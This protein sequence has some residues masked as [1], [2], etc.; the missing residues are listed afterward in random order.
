MPTF[1]RDCPNPPLQATAYGESAAISWTPLW[2]LALQGDPYSRMRE[3]NLI[4][5]VSKQL[6]EEYRRPVHLN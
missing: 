2:P 5:A 6:R 1:K 3:V 4:G